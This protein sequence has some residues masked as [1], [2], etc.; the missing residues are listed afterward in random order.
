YRRVRPT[1]PYRRR[2]RRCL[3]AT[4]GPRLDARLPSDGAG[5]ASSTQFAADLLEAADRVWSGRGDAR[6]QVAGE[7]Q[8]R[9]ARPLDRAH[10]RQRTAVRLGLAAGARLSRRLGR[11]AVPVAVRARAHAPRVASADAR[12]ASDDRD[13]DGHCGLELVLE[14]AAAR[15]PPLHRGSAA[16]GRAGMLGRRTRPVSQ[17]TTRLDSA[18]GAP[19]ADDH[20]SPR[21]TDRASPWTHPGRAHALAATL[22]PAAGAGMAGH[23][24]QIG[25]A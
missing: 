24:S 23:E 6:A 19:L 25:R 4:A 2:R 16:F 1:I 22:P 13:P 17:R 21:P 12:V 7:V 15:R 5:V 11:G 10:V 8:R 9:R 20:A 18:M 3:L 14:P